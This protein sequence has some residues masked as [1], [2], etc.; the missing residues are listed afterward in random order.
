M[1]YWKCSYCCLYFLLFLSVEFSFLV[2]KILFVFIMHL[3]D[4]KSRL[5][6]DFEGLTAASVATVR[7]MAGG[8]QDDGFLE[9]LNF[10]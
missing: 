6:E 4:F 3:K 10:V 5:Q 2:L 1:D 7:E 8:I 9:E